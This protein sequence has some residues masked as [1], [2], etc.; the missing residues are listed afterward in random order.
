MSA[1]PKP[2][3]PRALPRP[4]KGPST[5]SLVVLEPCEACHGTGQ[6]KR[7]SGRR[8]RLLREDAKVGLREMARSIF[9]S[10]AFLSDV[11]LGRRNASQELLTRYMDVLS[12]SSIR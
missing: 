12:K 11:E 2:V 4:R 8:M 10:A 9:V 7:I 1:N 3:Q 6:Q 5:L